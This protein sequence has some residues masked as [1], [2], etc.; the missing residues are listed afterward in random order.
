MAEKISSPNPSFASL[1]SW[2]DN[3]EG[4]WPQLFL[5]HSKPQFDMQ[6][7]LQK[8]TL[9]IQNHQ[10]FWSNKGTL[11]S[12]LLPPSSLFQRVTFLLFLGAGHGGG[13]ME[14]KYQ[15]VPERS[16]MIWIYEVPH[17]FTDILVDHR[18]IILRRTG[19]PARDSPGKSW[20][21]SQNHLQG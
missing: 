12:K 18:R 6:S 7:S 8:Y 17:L 11:S 13:V 4:C 9:L 21:V 16:N 15:P 20:E 2:K 3:R 14:L 19:S 5:S 1:A 10:W